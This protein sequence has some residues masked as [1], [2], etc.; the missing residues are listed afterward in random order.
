MPRVGA[1]VDFHHG[2]DRV[3]AAGDFAELV[4]DFENDAA[5]AFVTRG[6]TCIGN[7]LGGDFC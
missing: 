1:A 3:L 6:D 4:D 5:F 7:E 2:R